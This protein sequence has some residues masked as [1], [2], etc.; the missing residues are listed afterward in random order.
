MRGETLN[1][2]TD[3]A[4]VSVGCAHDVRLRSGGTVVLFDAPAPAAVDVRGG[5]LVNV[6]ATSYTY[7]MVS[8]RGRGAA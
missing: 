5:G 3:V 8:W 4:G 2:I 1:L 6:S 7:Q